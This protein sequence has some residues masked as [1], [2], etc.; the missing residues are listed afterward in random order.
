MDLLNKRILYIG[1]VYF[2]YDKAVINKL[3]EL[4]AQV[5]PFELYPSS[6]YFKLLRKL[7]LPILKNYIFYFYNKLLTKKNYDYVLVRHGHV[8]DIELLK[9]LRKNN[10]KARFVNFHWDS[11]KPDYNYV[12]LIKY[13][14]KVFSF[15]YKDCQAH[16]GLHY[17]P[18]FFLDEYAHH[19]K[20]ENNIQKEFDLLFI[21][22]W[23]NI[24]RWNLVKKADNICKQ[25]QLRFYYF[26]HYSFK[27]QFDSIKKGVLARD[28]INKSLS[29]NEILNLFSKSHCIIDFPSSFQTGLT[30][31]TFETLGAGKKLIT[32]NK[33][34][35]NEP[36][37][38]PEFIS[39]IDP[40]NFKLDIDF[41]RTPPVTSMEEK[42][43]NYSIKN[44]LF[45]L[46]KE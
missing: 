21:G 16:E 22:S 36:F 7:K 13:F 12:S 32:T 35:I 27:A 38:N 43:N 30:M 10:S 19:R 11:I 20:N 41:I 1:P 4:G 46:L 5:D 18:L 23:R 40:E 8:L 28:S 34:I 33:N 15:D 44:Y 3:I 25:N 24:E 6:V 45:N 14:D 17:L 39:I 31:R 42:I 9:N 37:Y 29:H 26:L 2:H